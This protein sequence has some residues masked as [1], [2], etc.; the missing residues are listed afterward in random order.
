[1][2]NLLP[3]PD[4]A[5]GDPALGPILPP[6]PP[7]LLPLSLT[8]PLMPPAWGSILVNPGFVELVLI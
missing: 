7:P 2:L 8:L 5:D 3:S 6:P 1:M 4:T